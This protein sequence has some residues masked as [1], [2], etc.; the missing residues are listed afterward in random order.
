M[1][2]PIQTFSRRTTDF[3]FGHSAA[4]PHGK[5]KN[6]HEQLLLKEEHESHNNNNNSCEKDIQ[7][8]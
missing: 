4:V 8:D 3:L 7:F 6:F 2:W 1:Y 5:P